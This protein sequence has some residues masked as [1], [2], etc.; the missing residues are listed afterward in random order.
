MLSRIEIDYPD[1]GVKIER[2]FT[3][4]INLIEEKNGYWKSTILN[5]ILSLYSKKYPG[6]R[7]L[8]AGIAKIYADDKVYMMSK[9][10]WVG[11]DETPNPLIRFCLPGEFFNLG[12]TTEQRKAIIEL[13]NIDYEKFMKDKVPEWTPDSEKEIKDRMKQNE[14]REDIIISDITR[15]TSAVIAYEKSP[16][17]TTDNTEEINALYSKYYADQNMDRNDILNSNNQIVRQKN[18]LNNMINQSKRSIQDL[19]SKIQSLR[20]K[21]DSIKEGKCSSCNQIV[22][23]DQSSVDKIVQEAKTLKAEIAKHDQSILSHQTELDSLVTKPVPAEALY[24]QD[25]WA[26]AKVLKMKWIQ[27]TEEGRAIVSQYDNNK[28]EL[29]LKQKQLKELGELNDKV[30][31]ASIA[32]AKNLFTTMLQDN[33]KE[34]NLEIELFK[35]QANGKL[36]ESFIIS[37]NGKPY[38]ELSNGNKLLLQIRMALAFIKKLGLD[39]ILIDELGT[40]SQDNFDMVCNEVWSLQMIIARATPF[41][42]PTNTDIVKVKAKKST[43]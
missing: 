36:V 33:I 40:M 4:G 7:T 11:L 24:L 41:V 23:V 2:D 30:L 6:L 14:G 15:L 43:K 3:P 32:S 19:E 28:R 29:A 34:F 9:G 37:L 16:F 27:F 10:M 35:E 22:P 42:V 17:D 25:V 26:R 13:L 1:F 5:T 31:L 20:E 18:D 21:R 12:S 8:P 38:G 39:F